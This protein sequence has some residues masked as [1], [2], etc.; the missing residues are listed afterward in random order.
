MSNTPPDSWTDWIQTFRERFIAKQGWTEKEAKLRIRDAWAVVRDGR[1]HVLANDSEQP[2]GAVPVFLM[3][4][5]GGWKLPIQI[6]ERLTGLAEKAMSSNRSPRDIVLGLLSLA[7]PANDQDEP[8][9]IKQKSHSAAFWGYQLLD[10]CEDETLAGV[11]G[12]D[13]FWQALL[14]AFLAGQRHTILE[15]YRDPQLLDDLIKAQAFQCGRSPDELTRRLEAS[16]LELRTELG[17]HPK[18]RQIAEAAGGVWSEIDDCW[19][20]DHLDGLPSVP[21]GSLYDRLDK[22]RRKHS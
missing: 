14:Y 11:I 8:D 9:E 17:R 2:A 21:N 15:L 19:Q 5:P 7:D 13:T 4:T 22:I 3:L 1:I 20:F 6:L 10:A 12:S 16:W 18:P